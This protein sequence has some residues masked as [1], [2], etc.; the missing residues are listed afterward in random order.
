[1][2]D[3][4]V[5]VADA[6]ADTIPPEVYGLGEIG[7]IAGPCGRADPCYGTCGGYGNS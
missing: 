2:G 4:G 1:L 6:A 3:H 7:R 5:I